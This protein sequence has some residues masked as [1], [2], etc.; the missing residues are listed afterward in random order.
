MGSMHDINYKF[1]KDNPEPDKE[2]LKNSI[3]QEAEVSCL[4]TI[5]SKISM[6]VGLRHLVKGLNSTESADTIKQELKEVNV[7]QLHSQQKLIETKNGVI[8]DHKKCNSHCSNCVR[9]KDVCVDCA[10]KGH[11][12]IEPELR[13]CDYC[14]KNQEKCNKVA[15]ICVSLNLNLEIRV[16]R[17]Y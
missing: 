3:V 8:K 10:I 14:M 1:V 16:V 15:V 12:N 5:D 4:S 7:C 6:E 11:T 2:M 9:N 13:A 17:N